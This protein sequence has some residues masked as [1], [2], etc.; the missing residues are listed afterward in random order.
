MCVVI[1]CSLRSRAKDMKIT[2]VI[3]NPQTG[4]GAGVCMRRWSREFEDFEKESVDSWDLTIEVESWSLAV[5][6]CS[7]VFRIS[8]DRGLK[9]HKMHCAWVGSDSMVSIT[10]IVS[11]PSCR[12]TEVRNES[13][14]RIWNDR[15]ACICIEWFAYVYVYI[16]TTTG[17][18]KN[19]LM[20]YT[21]CLR[22]VDQKGHYLL[23]KR[24]SGPKMRRRVGT[25]FL[26]AL[27]LICDTADRILFLFF[28]QM[29]MRMVLRGICKLQ[30]VRGHFSVSNLSFA[31][32]KFPIYH[33]HFY[34]IPFFP[35]FIDFHG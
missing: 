4:N 19:S 34:K 17:L 2:I 20:D 6:R 35:E 21:K 16:C 1:W 11:L 5:E 15:V 9:H 12:R 24:H 29:Y 22:L 26:P 18:K 14:V 27:M 13:T 30:N 33:F 31:F 8:T 25:Y 32:W 10:R 7:W 3:I 23:G 28:F